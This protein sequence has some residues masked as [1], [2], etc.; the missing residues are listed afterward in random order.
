MNYRFFGQ[1][2]HVFITIHLIRV[3]DLVKNPDQPE[4]TS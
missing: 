2:A 1:F 3:A 4:V